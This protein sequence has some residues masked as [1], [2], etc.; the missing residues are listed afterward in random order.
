MENEVKVN[1]KNKPPLDPDFVPAVLW[2]K[3]Y[4][5]M[6]KSNPDSMPVSIAMLRPDGTCFV[7][8]TKVLPDE[9]SGIGLNKKY[10]SKL[11]KVLLW[12]KG[13]NKIII[14]GSKIIADELAGSFSANG[15][16][17]FDSDLIGTKVF[18][19]PITVEACPLDRMPEPHD[20]S[21]KLGRNLDG[22]RIGFDL[23]G[24]DRKCAA[25]INGKVV[26]SEEVVWDPYYQSDPQYHI[27]GINDIIKRAAVKLPRIDAIGGSAAGIYMNNE[28]RV[29]SL[30][31]AISRDNFDKHI[32]GLFLKL[33]K[34]WGCV[35]FEVVNDGEVT[36][37]AA[38]MSM[39]DNAVL[40]TSMGTSQAGGYVTPDGNITSW[41]NE[42]AFVPVDYRDNAPADE[43]SGDIGCGVQ[44]FSQQ[45]VAR[46]IPKAGISVPDS[47]PLAERLNQIQKLMAG[48]DKR[49]E[50]IY[51]TIGI[52]LGYSIPHYAEFYDMRNMFILGRVTSGEGG[53]II[54]SR[55]A[56]ILKEEFPVL[57]EKIKISTPDEQEKRHGQAIAAASLPKIAK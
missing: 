47:M 24:S 11:I 46:L 6:V 1:V 9:K 16:R 54:I 48:G 15:S 45:A 5:E 34:E 12:Q 13:G 31:R 28:V 33:K 41:L 14:A 21:S 3:A 10:I 2:N 4:Q 22:C 38:S 30:F 53:D 20:A 17:A 37:L 19:S 57:A 42:L 39:N 26:H 32:R 44:Y 25:V 40:G 35:P 23:G 43:W 55:A 8:R 50:A 56:Q 29:A 27:S 52:Y 36:A 51:Q 18:G 49:A 7:H